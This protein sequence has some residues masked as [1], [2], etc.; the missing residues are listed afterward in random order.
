MPATRSRK[1][2]G[3]VSNPTSPQPVTPPS[4]TRAERKAII[5]EDAKHVLEELLDYEP[6]DVFYKIFKRESKIGGVDDILAL[7]KKDILELS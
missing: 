2:K 1:G 3:I 7:P 4:L 6:D 5:D